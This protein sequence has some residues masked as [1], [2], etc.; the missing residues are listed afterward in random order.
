MAEPR[1][2][3]AQGGVC[4][5]QEERSRDEGV[6]QL[7]RAAGPVFWVLSWSLRKGAAVLKEDQGHWKVSG[8]LRDT[9]EGLVFLEHSVPQGTRMQVQHQGQQA[10]G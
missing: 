4:S 3:S 1:T 5:P 6:E 7:C 9:Q 10:Q 8:T 2:L